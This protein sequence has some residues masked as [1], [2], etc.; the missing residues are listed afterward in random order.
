[1]TETAAS[2]FAVLTGKLSV[3]LW[4]TWSVKVHPLT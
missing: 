1:M 3:C 2:V 4:I